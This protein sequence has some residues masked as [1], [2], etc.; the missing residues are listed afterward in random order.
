MA[1]ES[2]TVCTVYSMQLN[3]ANEWC[4]SYTSPI[5]VGFFMC[6]IF[7]HSCKTSGI[8]FRPH[9]VDAVDVYLLPGNH[10]LDGPENSFQHLYIMS[11]AALSSRHPGM[12]LL[13][14]AGT[15]EHVERHSSW[16]A[17]KNLYQ[18]PGIASL[19]RSYMAVWHCHVFIMCCC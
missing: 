4:M 17:G 3:I 7:S 15:W 1:L 12:L 9:S 2:T 13:T 18:A 16:W 6:C 5:F 8:I 10:M 14:Y 19:M 11:C